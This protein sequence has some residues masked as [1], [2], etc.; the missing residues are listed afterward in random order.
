MPR[1]HLQTSDRRCRLR[2]WFVAPSLVIMAMTGRPAWSGP[3][4]PTDAGST[5]RLSEGMAYID[6]REAA[7]SQGWTP[8]VDAQ[9]KAN[10]VGAN[11]HDVC[12]DSPAQCRVCDELPELSACSGDG[13][14]LM[15][16]SRGAGETLTVSTYGEV[17]TWRA[18]RDA[19]LFVKWWRPTSQSFP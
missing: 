5:L 2:A 4:S 12:V 16:F 17:R 6:L 15:R 14:C 13:H 9:C 19:G 8:Q 11:F 1:G 7:L 3:A 18:K 10:V